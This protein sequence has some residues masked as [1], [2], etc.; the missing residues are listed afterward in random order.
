MTP[1]C[2]KKLNK[3]KKI[4]RETEGCAIA[5]SGGVDSSL[6]LTVADEVLGNRCLA[7][8]ATSSTY[9]QREYEQA[10]DWAKNNNIPHVIIASEELDIPE[11]SANPTDRCYYCKKE[12]FAKVK[13]QADKYGLNCVADGSNADDV[14]DYRPGMNAA[15]ELGVLSPLK[16]ASLTKED[17][18]TIAKEVYHLPMADKPSMACL[19]SRFPYGSAITDD[20]LNQIEK[21][22][23]FLQRE[24][25][26]IYRARHH[27]EILRLELG[28]EEMLAV[29]NSDLRKRIT[30]FVKELGFIYVT[31]DLE[32][33]RTGSMNEGLLIKSQAERN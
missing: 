12:L 8:I 20:K 18:R 19:A 23:Q 26:R 2:A 24:G 25:F 5:F 7:V 27:G 1:E 4:L 17:I 28:K 21:I 3:L 29:M 33:Y 15:C 10:V 30:M 32:G 9:P 31:L 22:E 6:L 13:E 14:G 16:E 11:F